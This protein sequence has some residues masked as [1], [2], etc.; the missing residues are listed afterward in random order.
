MFTQNIYIDSRIYK[1]TKRP[2][3]SKGTES[4]IK[5]L[6]TKKSPVPHGSAGKL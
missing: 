4:V 6:P 5:N 2:I 1:N 3:I